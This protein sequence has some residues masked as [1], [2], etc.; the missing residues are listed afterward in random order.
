MILK[1][2]SRPILVEK[3]VCT[4]AED[5]FEL[6]D[7]TANYSSPIWVAMEYRYMPVSQ[8]LLDKVHNKKLIGNMHSISIHEHRFPFLKKVG[9]WNRFNINTGGTLVEKCCH[10]FDL[11]RLITRDEVIQVYASGGQ[12][13]NFLDETYNGKVPDIL[14]NAFVV[15][16]FR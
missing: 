10:F 12:D 6:L 11:M 8:I 16:E 15:L 9:D 7:L 3:P 2:S 5:C 14:D 13:V 4:T 1:S